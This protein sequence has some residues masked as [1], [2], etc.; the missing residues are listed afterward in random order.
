MI[1]NGYIQTLSSQA[2]Y[3]LENSQQPIG[4]IAWNCGY[5]N[6]RSFHRNLK[7]ITR[8]SPRKYREHS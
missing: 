5:N 6:L 1:T 3:Q 8:F 4:E 7:K 2:C